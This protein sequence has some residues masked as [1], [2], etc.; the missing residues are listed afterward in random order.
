MAASRFSLVMASSMCSVET[1][2]SLKLA[3]SLK[4]FSSIC[5]AASERCACVAPLP[6]TLGSF[7]ISRMASA[8]HRRHMQPYALQQRRDD[9]F[10]VFQQRRQNV[11]RLQLRIAVLA[12]EIVRPLHRFLRFHS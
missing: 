9:A 4:A 1:Y 7:S 12:G 6:E 10:A 2:S 5:E 3:A 11:H 8:L